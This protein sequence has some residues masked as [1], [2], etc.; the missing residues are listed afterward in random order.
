MTASRIVPPSK[1]QS[2]LNVLWSSLENKNKMRASLFNLIFYSKKSPRDEYIRRI[3]QKIIEKF[4]ARIF[5]ISSE[6]GDNNNPVRTAVSIMSAEQGEF[7]VTC[8]FI[9]VSATDQTENQVPFIILPHIIADLPI[10]L[11]WAEDP[12]VQTPLRRE[13]EKF[14]TRLIFDSETAKDLPAFAKSILKSKIDS[15]CEIADLNWARLES[16]RDLLTAIFN[17]PKNLSTLKKVKKLHISYNA[18]ET[19]FFCHTKIQSIYLQA[20]LACRLQWS[21]VNSTLKEG[22]LNFTYT[23]AAKQP[24]E[25]TISSQREAS[26]P[27][28]LIISLDLSDGDEDF[29]HFARTIET[30]NEISYSY[31]TR[32]ECSLPTKFLIAK[33]ESGQS[34]VK[35]ICHKGTSH[36]YL[37]IVTLLATMEP[38]SLC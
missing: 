29:C 20:W 17:E 11:V 9:E 4:P 26:L 24:V 7:D 32:S 5:F 10:F 19:P 2:E 27:P 23:D 31:S 12:T 1:I 28:G 6:T 25:V 18:Q 33:G 3:A 38:F 35:E 15:N 37:E 13:L 36:H 34:L 14:A 30:P 21:F 8:D 22:A 16:W